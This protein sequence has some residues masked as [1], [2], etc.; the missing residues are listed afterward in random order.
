MKTLIVV[1]ILFVTAAA[2]GLAVTESYAGR[3]ELIGCNCPQIFRPVICSNGRGYD[4]LC[5][6][7]CDHAKHCVPAEI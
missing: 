6:A 4:N 1:A 7:R 3:T 2:A 5:Y